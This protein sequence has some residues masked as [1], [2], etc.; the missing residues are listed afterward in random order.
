MMYLRDAVVLVVSMAA[1]LGLSVSICKGVDML[2]D[3]WV[4][5]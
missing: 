3:W 4:E 5:R 2:K 1:V